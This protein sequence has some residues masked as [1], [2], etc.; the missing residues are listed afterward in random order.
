MVDPKIVDTY[1]VGKEGFIVGLCESLGIPETINQALESVDGRPVYIPYGVSAMIMMVNMCHD[2]RALSR[3]AEYYEYSEP[4]GL[5]HYPVQLDQL[6]DDRFGGLLDLLYEAGCRKI[7]TQ[8]AAK[9]VS[10]YGIEVKS[11]KYTK[12]EK[13]EISKNGCT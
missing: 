3:L 13:T 12:A 9:A 7:F 8:I 4:E 11:E 2:H 5:F 6:N 1:I 10:L